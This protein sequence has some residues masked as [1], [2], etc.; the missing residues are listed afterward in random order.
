MVCCQIITTITGAGSE[1]SF[2]D[3]TSEEGTR[4]SPVSTERALVTSTI[5]GA[6]VSGVSSLP[7]PQRKP[8]QNVRKINALIYV[9]V[10]I[11]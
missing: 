9:Q 5:T 2:M 7:Q 4:L 10:F 1:L 8:T 6:S 11:T 3:L